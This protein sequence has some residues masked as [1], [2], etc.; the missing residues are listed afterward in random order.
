MNLE[1]PQDMR[2]YIE[3]LRLIH[4]KKTCLE[5]TYTL[6][7]QKYRGYR[8]FTYLKIFEILRHDINWLWAQQ[9]CLHCTHI[10]FLLKILLVQSCVFT[11]EDIRT[12]WTLIWYISP[13]QYLQVRVGKEWIDV[14]IWAHVYGIPLGDHAHGFH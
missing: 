14:D 4:D 3:K 9:G 12:R 1:L 7:V 5:F 10:N 8:L 6:L 11:E 13:H 2:E